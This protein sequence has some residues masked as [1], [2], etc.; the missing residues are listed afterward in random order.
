M[1]PW[2]DVPEDAQNWRVGNLVFS[3]T[4]DFIRKALAAY[5]LSLLFRLRKELRQAFPDLRDKYNENSKYFGYKGKL[6]RDAVYVYVQQEGLVI[7]ARVSNP[8][9]WVNAIRRAGFEVRPTE[10]DF[11]DVAGWLTGVRVPHRTKDTGPVLELAAA[12]MRGE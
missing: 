11:Q 2:K 4:D 12:A 7:K 3:P 5:P 6:D 9:Q 1:V 10:G 8:E